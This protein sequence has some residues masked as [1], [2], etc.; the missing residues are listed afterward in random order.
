[1]AL[2]AGHRRATSTAPPAASSPA[3]HL[4]PITFR[5]GGTRRAVERHPSFQS[6]WKPKAS[7][8]EPR[9]S[10]FAPDALRQGSRATPP[11]CSFRAS[12]A[13][14][15]SSPL[16]LPGALFQGQHNT[17]RF[18]N[19]AEEHSTLAQ[20]PATHRTTSCDRRDSPDGIRVCSQEPRAAVTSFTPACDSGHKP[21]CRS[22]SRSY[23]ISA[24]NAHSLAVQAWISHRET[25][26]RQ[27]HEIPFSDVMFCIVK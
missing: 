23:T 22:F 21:L 13:A 24:Q 7:L 14:G 8:R 11:P 12:A 10:A 15:F 9:G 16:P 25:L 6:G 4:C 27:H 2:P 18:P 17:K 3:R 1:M 19:L 26:V 5:T 20:I